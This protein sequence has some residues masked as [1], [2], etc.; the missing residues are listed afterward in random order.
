MTAYFPRNFLYSNSLRLS[1]IQ[2]VEN[3]AF[4]FSPFFF[5]TVSPL[6]GS[7]GEH[8]RMFIHSSPH[9][10]AHS[11]PCYKLEKQRAAA[12]AASL[13]ANLC[14]FR[15]GGLY[16]PSLPACQGK[17]S[18]HLITNPCHISHNTLLLLPKHELAGCT[19][20]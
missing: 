8:R 3:I 4:Y 15:W 7:L 11:R 19:G 5:P 9:A 13:L 20:D 6:P 18:L 2:M 17:Q 14:A 12:A 1:Y 10:P 16:P